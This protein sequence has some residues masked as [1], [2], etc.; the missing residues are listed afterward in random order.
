MDYRRGDAVQALAALRPPVAKKPQIAAAVA[1]SAC[2]ALVQPMS[3][4]QLSLLARGSL[5]RG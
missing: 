3:M 1:S 4:E 2:N 5:E